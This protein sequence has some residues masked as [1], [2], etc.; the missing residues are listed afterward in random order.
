MK[1]IE[2]TKITPRFAPPVN[3]G[4]DEAQI[5]VPVERIAF[6]MPTGRGTHIRLIGENE[7]VIGIRVKQSREE[8]CAAISKT[9]EPVMVVTAGGDIEVYRSCAGALAAFDP[10]P[11]RGCNGK[12]APGDYADDCPEHGSGVPIVTS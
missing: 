9:G 11:S 7:S 1:Q 2:L 5:F 8:I 3:L 12:C 10:A 6:L 4:D